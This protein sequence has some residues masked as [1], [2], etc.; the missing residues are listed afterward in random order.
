MSRQIPRERRIWWVVPLA[1]L[2][3]Y[4]LS[5]GPAGYLVIRTGRGYEVVRLVYRPLIQFHDGTL[6]G[7]ALKWY[8]S[9]WQDLA[10]QA[11]FGEEARKHLGM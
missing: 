7:K 1:L 2:L 10:Q 9:P 5:I 8:V 6:P 3:L 11:R 4:P